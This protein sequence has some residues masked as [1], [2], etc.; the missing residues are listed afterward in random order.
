MSQ[1]R[2]LGIPMEGCGPE[3]ME[4]YGALSLLKAGIAYANRVTTVSA[5]YAQEIT[6]PAFGCGMEGFLSLKARQGLLS[7]LL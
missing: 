5:T 6:T 7:G 1:R 4:F 3:R 2:A